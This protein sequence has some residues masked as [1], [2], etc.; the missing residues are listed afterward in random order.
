MA[1][2]STINIE[3]E[4]QKA[5]RKLEELQ[6]AFDKQADLINQ[7]SRAASRFERVIKKS[8]TSATKA[9]KGALGV[10]L[11]LKSAA[12]GIVAAFSAREFINFGAN[13]E[14]QISKLNALT[15]AT[16]TEQLRLRKAIR[17][18][19]ATTAFTATQAAEAANVLAALGRSSQQI[20]RELGVVVK[21]A[22]ATGT[23]IETV[24]EAVAAQMN[25]F[26]ESAKVV[27][28]VFAAAYSTSAA[29]VEKLQTAL[30][31]V[32]PVAKA[33]G[34]NLTQTAGAISF[35]VDRGFRA[36]AAGT[37]LR[38][39]LVRLI[40]P[41]K[42][43]LKEFD[44]LGISFE[45]I[46][47]LSFQDQMQSIADRLGSVASQ[48]ERNRILTKIFG[49][50]ALAAA[51]NFINALQEGNQVIDTQAEKLRN[52]TSAAGLYNR[53]TSDLRGAIDKLISAVQDKLLTAFQAAEP[54]IRG[55]VDQLKDAVNSLTTEDVIGAVE[56][57]GIKLV[58][59]AFAFYDAIRVA[60]N[61][62]YAFFNS[63]AFQNVIE[64]AK[65]AVSA[66]GFT[67][68]DDQIA[69]AKADTLFY[70]K[71][72]TEI[73]NQ[74]SKSSDRDSLFPSFIKDSALADAQQELQISKDILL[75][76]QKRKAEQS[77][78]LE[79]VADRNGLEEYLIGKIREGARVI[80]ERAIAQ[81]EIKDAVE[82]QVT[83]TNDLGEA[84]NNLP[85]PKNP[86]GALTGAGGGGDTFTPPPVVEGL[87]D[88][89]TALSQ[90]LTVAFEKAFDESE[91]L[92]KRAEE[93]TDFIFSINKGLE[94]VE[95]SGTFNPQQVKAIE[96]ALI[97]MLVLAKELDREGQKE[98]LGEAN[99]RANALAATIKKLDDARTK[100]TREQREEQDKIAAAIK[101][102]VRLQNHTFFDSIV[103][104]VKQVFGFQEKITQEI[105]D[106][107]TDEERKAELEKQ[108]LQNAENYRDVIADT[109]VQGVA[110]AGPNASR[111]VSAGKAFAQGAQVGG[112]LAGAANMALDMV[113]SNE[114]VAKAIDSSFKLFFDVFDPF[115]E[116]IADLIDAIN[117]LIGALLSAANDAISSA[118]ENFNLT[119]GNATQYVEQALSNFG[120]FI[121]APMGINHGYRGWDLDGDGVVQAQKSLLQNIFENI[122]TVFEEGFRASNPSG[123]FRGLLGEGGRD[124]TDFELTSQT[125]EDFTKSVE[126]IGFS[127][128]MK[129]VTESMKE[130]FNSINR[131]Y[132]HGYDKDKVT[133]N[134]KEVEAILTKLLTEAY[135]E[136]VAANILEDVGNIQTSITEQIEKMEFDALTTEQQFARLHLD[137]MDSLEEQRKEAYQT[138][139]V[140]EHRVEVLEAIKKAEADSALL[141][142][143]QKEELKLLNEERERELV[144]LQQNSAINVLQRILNDF[145]KTMK[146]ISELVEGLFDQVSELL[147]SEFNLAPATEK[148]EIA[149][150]KYQTL[151]E[152]AFS[153]D[154]TEEDIENL[155]GF[156]NEYLKSARDVY[157]SSSTFQAIF[158][159]VL[160]DLSM[161]GVTT[162]FNQSGD[163]VSGATGGIKEFI[164]TTEELDEGLRKTLDNL[165]RELNLLGSAFQEQQLDFIVS[166]DGLDI[167]LELSGSDF[168]PILDGDIDL[169]LTQ[170]DIGTIG[171]FDE[172]G[173]PL[174]LDFT[175]AASFT[176]DISGFYSQ[177][178]ET[179][180]DSTRTEEAHFDPTITG[181][182][183]YSDQGSASFTADIT[184][185]LSL[186]KSLTGWQS[187]TNNGFT[188]NAAV[189]AYVTFSRAFS[190]FNS[191]NGNVG[192]ANL[193][194][195]VSASI[196]ATISSIDTSGVET[197]VTNSIQNMLDNIERTF[198]GLGQL[199][200]RFT[201]AAGPTTYTADQSAYSNRVYGVQFPWGH[202]YN[203]PNGVFSSGV[204]EGSAAH[205]A[206]IGKDLATRFGQD[207]MTT[208][209]YV[210]TRDEGSSKYV[211]AYSDLDSAITDYDMYSQGTYPVK[212]YG[213]RFGGMV[214]PEDTIPAMLSA[215]EY[216]LSPETVKR[217]GV[218]SL[219]R[220]NHGD[221]SAL[222]QTNDPEVKRLLA[223]LI[224]AV[225][226]TPTDVH[227]YTDMKG[228]AKAAVSEFR[229]EL[230][231]RTRRQ[232]D[233]FVPAKY[234]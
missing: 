222:A 210:I 134:A 50:E 143:K 9:V 190:N 99:A 156:V 131:L 204:V 209:P 60:I 153:P 22:G 144:L 111:G 159:S 118:F 166:E 14:R 208:N 223:E 37:A 205:F 80:R 83:A 211:Y 216:I 102:Q 171:F 137:R 213:F 133:R 61:A 53:M 32:G 78:S 191:I 130:A 138:I 124:R 230:K 221:S 233:Q 148:L 7:A 192:T 46:Q 34:L 117:S 147:L 198:T 25:V 29:N 101:E 97:E 152:A 161:L 234:I 163:A 19:G 98:T 47:K 170:A 212:K 8:M 79:L 200:T 69:A 228:E 185:N 73:S 136:N 35:L 51:N 199:G 217:F 113:M 103:K 74:Q 54:F 38:G 17:E 67:S 227:V 231:E 157:K 135:F 128:T 100:A 6:Q 77:A 146:G 59:G 91:P 13:Y 189:G 31:Q 179:Y 178:L 2:D 16:T 218:G 181:F 167:A 154:A 88:P 202:D 21:V 30:G 184:G 207:I 26:G 96:G 106:Q 149:S 94:A 172:E 108:R 109:L 42:T 11:N 215:G 15:K 121:G 174:K 58:R 220:L 229:S 93:L 18:V 75:E 219:N 180:P 23:A 44:A 232:G 162:G 57:I 127:E 45:Q 68:L 95:K 41:T 112:P 151:L 92:A 115:I 70:I 116:T 110:S 10:F 145:E 141:L 27:G 5:L 48:A 87:L 20:S 82:G 49:V 85:P 72:V 201:V 1:A 194:A 65:N 182:K 40:D 226:D 84:Q 64:V 196:N 139:E 107:L 158:A 126:K 129:D 150:D 177:D 175:E 86:F 122:D 52:A 197:T 105:S 33:A 120:A 56:S 187:I 114:K 125:L 89:F 119:N 176:A 225:K 155:Q 36:E 203:A 63:A 24:S 28:D 206:S 132:I 165:I 39:V 193:V 81:R 183:D 55:I 90:S 71:K 123:E 76:L 4:L 140:E 195:N 12:V 142:N 66:L 62:L 168:K 224:V 169:K 173:N 43:V 104:S 214:H 160:D 3:I 188:G 164:E 186:T